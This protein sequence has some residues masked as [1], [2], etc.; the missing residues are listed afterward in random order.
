MSLQI[1]CLLR[2]MDYRG[3]HSADVAI[4]VV[5]EPGETV[6]TLVK[7]LLLR[8]GEPHGEFVELRI[9]IEGPRL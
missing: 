5:V 8:P 4:A 1:S 3:D 9:A 2:T 6:E 7:R